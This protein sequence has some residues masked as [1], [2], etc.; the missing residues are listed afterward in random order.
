MHVIVTMVGSSRR[1]AT[2]TTEQYAA[3]R[4]ESQGDDA[5]VAGE[6]LCVPHV[7]FVMAICQLT[8]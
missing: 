5:L 7:L 1:A 8:L 2:V 4:V 6:S 3:R